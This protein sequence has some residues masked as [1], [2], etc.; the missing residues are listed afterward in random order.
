MWRKQG[1]RLGGT[2]RLLAQN[3]AWRTTGSRA[4]GWA[5]VRALESGDEMLCTMAGMMLVR[6]GERALPLVRDAVRQRIGLPTS[7]TVLAD[8]GQAR[9]TE[10]VRGFASDFDPEVRAAAQDALELL[11]F[12]LAG[13]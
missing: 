7:L 1:V 13:G 10:L 8:I 4:A 12:R 9:D 5:I 3:A 6:S 2:A 11:S